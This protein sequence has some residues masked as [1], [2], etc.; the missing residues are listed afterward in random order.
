ML[1]SGMSEDGIREPGYLTPGR[2][3]RLRQEASAREHAEK[4]SRAI[5]ICSFSLRSF[6]TPLTATLWLAQTVTGRVID[7]VRPAA[8][9]RLCSR[10]HSSA[11]LY[12]LGLHRYPTDGSGSTCR[13]RPLHALKCT[14]TGFATT[15]AACTEHPLEVKLELAPVR[16]HVVVSATRSA[17]A[18]RRARQRA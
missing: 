10:D 13:R 16:E 9:T 8:P 1:S 6:S 4:E 2:P 15:T 18:G 7:R 14:L 3:F 17:H 5:F 12:S 11:V